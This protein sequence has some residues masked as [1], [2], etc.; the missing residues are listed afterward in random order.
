MTQ[1]P[2]ATVGSLGSRHWNTPGS[3]FE[4]R[5][6]F[7][8]GWGITLASRPP[9]TDHGGS[10]GD[11]GQTR[12]GAIYDY[13]RR[14]PGVHVRGLAKD[15][16][17]AT[18]DLQYHLLWLER[19][20]HLKTRKS[21]FYRFVYPTML[22]SD[23]EELL[24]AVLAQDTPREI[25]LCLVTEGEMTQGELAKALGHSQPTVSWHM[26]RLVRHGLVRK[27]NGGR[28]MVYGSTV[29]K[30]VV[31]RFVKTYHPGVWRRWGPRMGGIV[32]RVGRVADGRRARLGS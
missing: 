29:E 15:L 6:G 9:P 31:L 32:V 22:F 10:W 16:G 13:V 14:H 1:V 25:I 30:D 23:R 8:R 2:E 24:L 4:G 5:A 28:G 12:R 17:I 18:G 3:W 27:S 19:H 11:S 21:G 7:D 20:G 26:E